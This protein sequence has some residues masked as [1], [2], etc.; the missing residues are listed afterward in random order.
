MIK[1]AIESSYYLIPAALLGS[2]TIGMKPALAGAALTCITSNLRDQI[3]AKKFLIE[4]FSM[5]E[6]EAELLITA[7]QRTAS[8][9]FV[10]QTDSTLLTKITL[11]PRLAYIILHGTIAAPALIGD[12]L[13][14]NLNI[15]QKIYD[16]FF[17]CVT[18]T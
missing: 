14:E 5:T 3:Q 15:T 11:P 16:Y 10:L 2:L 13:K 17:S 9:F 7:V 18:Q 8:L 4:N 1:Q 6:N 12:A